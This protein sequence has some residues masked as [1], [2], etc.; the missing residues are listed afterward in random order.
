[1]YRLKIV[2]VGGLW[3]VSLSVLAATLAAHT[4]S[5]SSEKGG[6]WQAQGRRH[7]PARSHAARPPQHWG[8]LAGGSARRSRAGF[9]RRA[10]TFRTRDIRR[11]R[12]HVPDVP[13][14]G[15]RHGL[16]PGRA[17]SIPPRN[18]PLFL[19][20]GSDDDDGNGFGDGL[21]AMRCSRTRPSSCGLRCIRTRS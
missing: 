2:M 11:Q 3:L 10:K 20:E 7:V 18:D 14:P 5:N 19:H 16:P 12:P 13:Q 17:A 1:M 15:N 4:D 21:K 6:W 8:G 9:S